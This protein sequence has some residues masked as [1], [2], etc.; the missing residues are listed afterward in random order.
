MA[1]SKVARTTRAVRQIRDPYKEAFGK[2]GTFP[3]TT[4]RRRETTQEDRVYPPAPPEWT[5]TEPEWAIY[6]AHTRLGKLEGADFLYIVNMFGWGHGQIGG[7]QIDFMEL[8]QPTA[9]NI[10][11]EFFHNRVGDA[12]NTQ[13]QSADDRITF[14]ALGYDYIAIDEADAERD[15][16]FYLTEALQGRDHSK[17]GRG[18]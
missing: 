8:D 5:G 6:W 14:S 7:L 12:A 1:E 3:V 10:Q 18:L 2:S 9:I 15:P 11:G 16:I 17:E 13:V 4:G